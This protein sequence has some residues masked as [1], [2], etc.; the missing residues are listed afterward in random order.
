MW[1][2]VIHH[3]TRKLTWSGGGHP[4]GLLLGSNSPTIQQ[5]E[6]QNPC[7]GM[8]DASDFEQQEIELTPN[9]RLYIYSDGAY[10]IHK[11]DGADWTFDEFISFM[12]QPHDPQHPIMDR[13]FRH[14][15]TLKGSETL[16]DDFSILEA[17]IE[18]GS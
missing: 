6:S 16:D 17:R 8:F 7:I 15:Q 11:L 13:L 9:S 12:S 5:L 10:E 1:Y 2:G 18:T 4:A 14:V 3:A